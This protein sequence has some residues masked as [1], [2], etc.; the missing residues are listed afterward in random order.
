MPEGV[1]EV[2]DLLDQPVR[3]GDKIAAAFRAGDVAQLRTGTVLG[4]GERS[5]KV[6][7]KV[8]WEVQSGYAKYMT[9]TVIGA[10]E[11][12][13]RRFVKIGA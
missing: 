3:K 5:G 4:F 1:T 8:Q 2:Y 11:A 10:I 6:T 9:T 13:L 7:V 12:D